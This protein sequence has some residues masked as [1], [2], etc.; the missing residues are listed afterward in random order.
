MVLSS[1]QSSAQSGLP[2]AS[3]PGANSALAANHDYGAAAA[4]AHQQAATEAAQQQMY[5]Q[6]GQHTTAFFPG[7]APSPLMNALPMIMNILGSDGLS[8]KE[9]YEVSPYQL[10]EWVSEGVI[11]NATKERIIRGEKVRVRIPNGKRVAVS[12]ESSKAAWSPNDL[13]RFQTVPD[14]KICKQVGAGHKVDGHTLPCEAIQDSLALINTCPGNFPNQDFIVVN[15]YSRLVNGKFRSWLI[16]IGKN[17][18]GKFVVSSKRTE[19]GQEIGPESFVVS[20]GKRN[21]SDFCSRG[22]S[23]QTP[24][25]HFLSNFGHHMP[26]SGGLVIPCK[27]S[28]GDCLLSGRYQGHSPKIGMVGIDPDLNDNSLSRGILIHAGWY[29]GSKDASNGCSV[30]PHQAIPKFWKYI[31]GNNGGALVH[32]YI[33][34]DES[35]VCNE[36]RAG[37]RS[38]L[39]RSPENKCKL[40][41]R[42]A[43]AQSANQLASAMRP[44]VVRPTQVADA[45]TADEIR[46]P[47]RTPAR[48]SGIKN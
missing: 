21:S 28:A 18:D 37:F 14:E 19:D 24:A 48:T 47:A 2:V 35:R 26:H 41:A 6:G 13:S 15:D 25:G 33:G 30:V 9:T 23:N 45:R 44:T 10:D 16:P 29:A 3:N 7:A 12:Y 43:K 36:D 4:A 20:N 32:N 34:K 27:S 31:G 5:F 11:N 8:K 39:S 1:I 38:A 40:M 46:G 17:A 22:G 42:S